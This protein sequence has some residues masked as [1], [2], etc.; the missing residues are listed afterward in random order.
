M[1]VRV[2][3]SIVGLAVAVSP[4]ALGQVSGGGEPVGGYPAHDPQLDGNRKFP[5]SRFLLEYEY[6]NLDHPPLQELFALPVVLGVVSD[7]DG[8]AYTAPRPGLPTAAV[9]VGDFFGDD[10][11]MFYEAAVGA[12]A[13]AIAEELTGPRSLI[14][15]RVVPHPD[16]VEWGLKQD[17]RV[18][19]LGM[20]LKVFTA[21][22]GGQTVNVQTPGTPEDERINPPRTDRIRFGTE[23][24][25]GNLLR[26]DLIDDYVARLNRHPGRRIDVALAPSSERAGEVELQFLLN[27]VKP[28]SLYA[29]V[30]NIGTKTTDEWRE[31]FGFVHN[32][33]TGA[34]DILRIDYLTAQFDSAHQFLAS[35][36][37]PVFGDVRGRV[38]GSFSQYKAADVG[39]LAQDFEGESFSL[40]LEF[41][42]NLYQSGNFFLDWVAGARLDSIRVENKLILQEG[43]EKFFLPYAGVKFQR[44]NDYSGVYGSGVVEFSMNELTDVDEQGLQDL[45]RIF[46]DENWVTF[47]YDVE[48]ST[49]IEPLLAP[50][51]FKTLDDQV[52][53]A[54]LAHELSAAIRG[55]F[56]FG[57]RLTP[58]YEGVAGGF[59]TVRGYPE[60]IAAGDDQVVVNLEYRFHLPRVL[61]T[62]NEKGEADYMDPNQTTLFGSPFKVGP[63]GPFGRT[64]WD[65]IF[66]GF[67]DVGR[68]INS[69]R[70]IFEK[71]YTLV[72]VGAGVEFQL[73]QN[74]QIRMDLGFA[75]QD[76]TTG[77]ENVETGDSRLHFSMTLLY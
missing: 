22:I 13:R 69:D 6:N 10:G 76:V 36:E 77:V 53:G 24:N 48:A 41:T 25:V 66:R 49:Y 19:R 32:Q 52:R 54:T 72:G 40:G 57:S 62:T 27:E 5:I 74:L 68:T 65:L 3:A 64:D 50:K 58:T 37:R 17:K 38:Y 23:W 46:P 73:L 70:Q 71:D 56:A 55:Q 26:K 31:R 60:S 30:A 51:E 14:G 39:F 16:D 67:L 20:R 28:W 2:L 15:V 7:K 75:M 43:D 18:G 42:G 44:V 12:V 11:A 34:D 59:Y 61:L 1:K 8:T 21:Y 29:Q 47:K 4:V 9:R 35:Y 63:A 33:L 45:G